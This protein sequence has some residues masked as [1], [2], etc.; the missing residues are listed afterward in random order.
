[1]SV[2]LSFGLCC[3]SISY[4]RSGRGAYFFGFT[5]L[6]QLKL[7]SWAAGV[8]GDGDAAWLA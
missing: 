8:S 7:P 5:E 6:P 4:T 3:L 1:M 2:L